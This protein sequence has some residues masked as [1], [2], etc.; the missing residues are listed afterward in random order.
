MGDTQ[1]NLSNREQVLKFLQAGGAD[2]AFITGGGLDEEQQMRMLY[3]I[4]AYTVMLADVYTDLNQ[5]PP[6]SPVGRS[7]AMRLANTGAV[8]GAA[9]IVPGGARFIPHSG[10][11]VSGHYDSVH[12]GDTI[13][14][15]ATEGTED[16]DQYTDTPLKHGR[17]RFECEKLRSSWKETTEFF[18]RNIMARTLNQAVQKALAPRLAYDFEDL[19]I[20]GDTSLANTNKR[21]RLLRTN[22]GWIKI[23]LAQSPVISHEGAYTNWEMFLRALKTV[24]DE[25]PITGLRWWL[26]PHA[27][28]DWVHQI[29]NMS[30]EAATNALMGQALAPLGI[31]TVQ[32]P[33]LPRHLEVVTGGTKPARVLST[34]PGPYI[35]KTGA[36]TLKI[37]V[38]NQGA[39]TVTFPTEEATDVESRLLYVDRV[40]NLINTALLAQYGA[41][42]GYDRVARRGQHGYLEFVS[43]SGAASE[44]DIQ[45]V[46]NDAYDILGLTVGVTVGAGAAATNTHFE[47]SLVWLAAPEQFGW[48]V[49]VSEPGASSNGVRMFTKFEQGQDSMLTDIYSFQDATLD[50]P[51]LMITVNNVRVARPGIDP[52]A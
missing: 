32:V 3:R 47:G 1:L 33:A 11:V 40:A 24:P 9:P 25:L 48:H 50:S 51:D 12:I 28:I 36:N 39:V 35:F 31:P 26:N 41:A 44:I 20:N 17:R 14:R 19:A 23:S 6:D 2:S 38:D 45:A 34:E 16:A 8:M 52:T 13:T 22:D 21:T 5:F 49:S 4:R 29:K 43:T 46:A 27:W 15:P 7:T 42:S 10:G 18:V 37:D 30:Q